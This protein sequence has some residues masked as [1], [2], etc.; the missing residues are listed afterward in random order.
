[1]NVENVNEEKFFADYRELTGAS[2]EFA[3]CVYILL[4]AAALREDYPGQAWSSIG[5]ESTRGV[6]Q[7]RTGCELRAKH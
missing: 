4:E 5:I 7:T 6:Q 1:M 3:R 2:E